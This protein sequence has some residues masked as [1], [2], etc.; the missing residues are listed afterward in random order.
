MILQ[1]IA[2]TITAQGQ[3]S[4]CLV[5][6]HVVHPYSSINIT[7]A[8]KKNCVLFY[9]SGLTFIRLI[10]YQLAVHAFASCMSISFSVDETLL[11]RQVNLSTSFR[12]PPFSVEM[13]LLWLKRMYS[14]SFMLTW[15]SM[16]PAARFR[17]FSRDVA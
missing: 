14:V 12:G 10:T 8:W 9:W 2:L 7:T 1:S 3:P 15:R 17:L 11:L 5:R 16:P 13:L 4:I 6:V